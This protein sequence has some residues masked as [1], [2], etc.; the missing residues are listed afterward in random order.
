MEHQP[1]PG[2]ASPPGDAE[3]LP[4]SVTTVTVWALLIFLVFSGFLAL[5]TWQV[6]RLHW[7]VDLIERVNQRVNAPAVAAPGPEKWPTITTQSDEYRH[8]TAT[9]TYRYDLTTR[10]QATTE[11]GGGFWLLTP[12]ERADGSVILVNRG[13]V[14]SGTTE[15][16]KPQGK[17]TNK[18]TQV[19]GLLRITEPGGG[20]LRDNDPAADRWHSR[21]VAAIAEARGLT[22]VAPYFIDADAGPNPPDLNALK[23]SWSEPVGGLTV[24]SFH[25]SHLGYAFTWYTLALM[26]AAGGLWV[27]REERRRWRRKAA[28]TSSSHSAQ[29]QRSD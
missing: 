27:A 9:G 14:S 21:D 26:V 23:T 19:T 18:M 4:N 28:S 17:N 1:H 25:N 16:P 11:L 3:P 7:K 12:L 20:F 24:I 13:F 15:P 6:Q 5:G 22:H 29:E 10:V 8:V 2:S